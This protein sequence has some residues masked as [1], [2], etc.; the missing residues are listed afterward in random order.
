ML[1]ILLPSF[2]ASCKLWFDLE[3]IESVS[4]LGLLLALEE[5]SGTRMG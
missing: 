4:I 5:V 3:L 2:F 1:L